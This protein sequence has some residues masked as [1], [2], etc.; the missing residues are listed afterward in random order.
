[1]FIIK[2]RFK[3]KFQTAYHWLNQAGSEVTCEASVQAAIKYHCPNSY[4]LV[5]IMNN[6]HLTTSLAT[7]GS[8]F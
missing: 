3:H 4:D 5:E 6:R 1:M 2:N 8:I 7:M